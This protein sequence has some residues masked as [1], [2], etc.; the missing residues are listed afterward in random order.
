MAQHE[1]GFRADVQ[2]LLSLVKQYA[3]QETLGPLR[4]VGR[5]LVFGVLGALCMALAYLFLV[6]ALMRGLQAVSFFDGNWSVL[7]Y[8]IALVASAGVAAVVVLAISGRSGK[9]S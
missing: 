1:G 3:Q 7:V 4:G 5:Y 2:G 8:L 6:L 9:G